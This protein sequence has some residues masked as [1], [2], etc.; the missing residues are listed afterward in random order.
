M[1]SNPFGNA[2]GL[3]KSKSRGVPKGYR[4]AAGAMIHHEP[5]GKVLFVRR[6]PKETSKHGMWELPG[7]K[8]EDGEHPESTAAIEAMEEVGLPLQN[9]K[10]MGSHVDHA[11]SKVYHG[12]QGVLGGDIDPNSVQLSEEHDEFRWVHPNDVAQLEDDGGLSHHA[13]HLFGPDP[14][15]VFMNEAV[16]RPSDPHQ[17]FSTWE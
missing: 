4:E 6:S 13:Q 2:W 12:Y 10:H 15:S 3:I 14:E 1:S 5:T 7:G 16:A 17:D 8:V 9:L 11:K